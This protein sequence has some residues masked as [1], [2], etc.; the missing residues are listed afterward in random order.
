[1]AETINE[2][3]K[4][5]VNFVDDLV[6][7][8]DD[9]GNYIYM[10]SLNPSRLNDDDLLL[11]QQKMKVNTY[12]GLSEQMFIHYACLVYKDGYEQEKVENIFHYFKE[13]DYLIR[14][15]NTQYSCLSEELKILKTSTEFLL[16]SGYKPITDNVKDFLNKGGQRSLDCLSD[17]ILESETNPLLKE[18]Y[19]MHNYVERGFDIAVTKTMTSDLYRNNKTFIDELKECRNELNNNYFRIN[20]HNLKD[21]M[22][23]HRN[24]ELRIIDKYKYE[25][26]ADFIK[27][28]SKTILVMKSFI[29]GVIYE[30]NIVHDG[31]IEWL[32]KRKP[33]EC[34]AIEGVKDIL[35]EDVEYYDEKNKSLPYLPKSLF[36]LDEKIVKITNCVDAL[37]SLSAENRELLQIQEHIAQT[38]VF[39]IETLTIEERE[40]LLVS[41]DDILDVYENMK[42]KKYG[43]PSDRKVLFEK[44]IFSIIQLKEALSYLRNESHISSS[45][46]M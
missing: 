11:R 2:M 41:I 16:T 40:T 37:E 32:E 17:V 5:V 9:L 46:K 25:T 1:M 29:D 31:L 3:K 12:E 33:E 24:V 6:Y 34:I 14:N 10:N 7:K 21:I 36:R 19:F 20:L 42:E 4:S 43:I 30:N 45:Y 13:V 35:K 38:V 27:D 18:I 39:G 22:V 44:K 15:Y 8:K 26:R 23:Y 28:L